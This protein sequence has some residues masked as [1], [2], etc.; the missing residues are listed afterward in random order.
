MMVTLP[1]YQRRGAASLSLTWGKQLA[2]TLN[3]PS[4]L[5]ASPDGEPVY[6]RNGWQEVDRIHL[7]VSSH[8]GPG[9]TRTHACM[10]LPTPFPVLPPSPIP[11]TI[12]IAPITSAADMPR[13]AEITDIAFHPDPNMNVLFPILATTKYS[14][15]TPTMT[16]EY[17]H[18]LH[19]DPSIRYL[20]AT[21][22]F[23]GEMVA[24]AKWNF[25]HDNGANRSPWSDHPNPLANDAAV[26]WF[27][28]E[29][30][31]NREA[32]MQGRPHFYMSMLMVLPDYQG[33]GIG[34][35]LLE[36]GLEQA[37]EMG[38]E[39]WIDA[40][41]VGLPL[42]KKLG[43]EPVAEFWTD[44]EKWG[45]TKGVFDRTTGCNRKPQARSNGGEK[46]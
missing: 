40:T 30:G 37:D 24:A 7:D 17:I 4:F 42:Y 18:L 43:W 33:R 10:I 1:S 3:L 26:A 22:T 31:K 32:C 12:T 34:K 44:C 20:K 38:M 13:A 14:A 41:D 25:W 5:T 6:R 2:A 29:T 45:G 8:Y 9:Q 23:T 39:V 28:G 15:P 16:D 46:A 11:D 27:F 35:R 36:W 21:D 19:T